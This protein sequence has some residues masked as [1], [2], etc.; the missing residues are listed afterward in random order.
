[1]CAILWF[2][3][4]CQQKHSCSLKDS[5]SAESWPNMSIC[6]MHLLQIWLNYCGV[7]S[8]HIINLYIQQSYFSAA[9]RCLNW[10]L[11]CIVFLYKIINI[12][13]KRETER[14]RVIHTFFL[15][16][17]I[18]RL[19][20]AVYYTFTSSCIKYTF[21]K[22]CTTNIMIKILSEFLIPCINWLIFLYQINYRIKF[23]PVHKEL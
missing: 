5:K 17:N 14:D 6:L 23:W 8:L 9:R 1:M 21:H 11:I 19:L 3:S 18:I 16:K 7:F 10:K 13:W 15:Y 12:A 4:R 2:L 20:L 22:A